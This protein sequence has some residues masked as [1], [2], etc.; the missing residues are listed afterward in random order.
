MAKEDCETKANIAHSVPP[1]MPGW[2]EI[3]MFPPQLRELK[4]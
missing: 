2:E 1:D 4:Y 3:S